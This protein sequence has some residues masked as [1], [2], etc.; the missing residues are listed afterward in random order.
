MLFPITTASSSTKAV[1]ASNAS[2]TTATGIRI[3]QHNTARL[4]HPHAFLKAGHIVPSLGA[5]KLVVKEAK[6]LLNSFAS[7]A[8]E[9]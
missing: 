8:H 4:C 9:L 7:K 3:P 6:S 5:P 2:I 1:P